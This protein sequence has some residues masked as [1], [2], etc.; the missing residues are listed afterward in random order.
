MAE[1]SGPSRIAALVLVGL[2]AFLLVAAILIPTYSVSSLEKIPLDLEV[3]TVSTG[4]GSVLDAESLAAGDPQVDQDVPFVSQRYVTVEDPS[5]ADKVTVQAG[6][7]LRRTDMQGETGLRSATV[8]RVTLDRVTAMPV[9]DPIGSIQVQGDAPAEEVEHTG[10]QY[11]FPFDAQQESYP[12][13]DINARASQPIDF[14]EETE[15]NGTPVYMYRQTVGPVDL[16]EVVTSPSNRVTLPAQAWGVEGGEEP[17][18]MSRFYEN[19][20]TLWVEPETGVIVKG[21]EQLLQYYSRTAGEP[22]VVVVDVP[23]TFDENTVEFQLDVAK[24]GMDTLSLFGR[25]IPIIAAI[26][27]AIALIAGIVLGIRGQ[28]G[29]NRPARRS[30]PNRPDDGDGSAT[31]TEPRHRDWTTDQTEV[32]PRTNLSKE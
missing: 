3:T 26:L 5:D 23:L 27:G 18:T 31:R 19:E 32:I 24:D 6:T 10:L 7:T 22:E 30:E 9:Q 8:D 25:T 28:G 21:D 16:S 11:K 14:V 29:N 1:R 17:V 12:Y 13:F 20:R 15:I 4:S 2:G